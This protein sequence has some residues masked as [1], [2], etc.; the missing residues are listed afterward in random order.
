VGISMIAEARDGEFS[1]AVE[2][3]RKILGNVVT[4]PGEE[5]Y[6]KLRASNAKIASLLATRGVRALL[7]GAG[8]EE[9]GDFLT[10]A[11]ETPADGVQAAIDKLDGEVARRAEAVDAAKADVIAQRKALAE[12]ENDKRKVMKMQIQDDA[13]AR[14][15]P[16]WTAKAAGV[17]GGKAITSCG[18][19]GAQGGGG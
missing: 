18:D 13:E 5:K 4:H 9:D 7:R 16:G 8:F 17:K 1:S 6:R 12:V 15:E 19:I 14:K 11:L 10:L 3:L 2:L